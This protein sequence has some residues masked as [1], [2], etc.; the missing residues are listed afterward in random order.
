[1]KPRFGESFHPD[2]TSRVNILD[3]SLEIPEYVNFS[4]QLRRLLKESSLKE[5]RLNWPDCPKN[6]NSV[7]DFLNSAKQIV[8]EK[9][10]ESAGTLLHQ[11]AKEWLNL[12]PPTPEN[13]DIVNLLSNERELDDQIRFLDLSRL[14]NLKE[15]SPDGWRTLILTSSERQLATL[16][17]VRHWFKNDLSDEQI[18]RWGSSRSELEI[19]LD[20]GGILGKYF[21]Q[22]YVKQIE[23]ADEPG[24]TTTSA[25]SKKLTG[26][27]REGLSY[28]YDVPKSPHS[29]TIDFKTYGE[30]FAGEWPK[31]AGGL[32]NLAAKIEKMLAAGILPKNNQ[33]QRIQDFKANLR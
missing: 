23:L 15:F 29:R 16:S 32:R 22:A 3:D 13:Q 21:D 30:V 7:E 24:G 4:R 33:N 9:W 31:V 17:L 12:I 18:A 6:L 14:E 1:M 5:G 19:L 25:L 11:Q 8:S 26:Q 28:I 10:Q 2:A 20:A 27:E